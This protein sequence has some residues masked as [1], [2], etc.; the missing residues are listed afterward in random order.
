MTCIARVHAHRGNALRVTG[1]F[2]QA[3][4]ALA[5][6]LKT[7][8]EDGNGD[9]LVEAEMLS[10]LASL[11]TDQ[12]KAVEA[13]G[14]IDMAAGI[15]ERIG[16]AAQIARL[17]VK[18]SVVVYGTGEFERAL[19][20]GMEA[21]HAIDREADPKLYL[22]AEHNCTIFLYER[23]RYREAWDRLEAHAALYD[24]FP[25]AWTQLRRRKLQGNILRGLGRR[26]EA[27]E[28]LIAARLGFVAEGLGFYAA[29]A[30]LDLAYLY[31]EERRT[32]EVKRLAE[33]MVP[34]FMAQD[35]HREAAASAPPVP[36]SSATGNRHCGDA[37]GTHRLHGAG[38]DRAPTEAVVMSTRGRSGRGRR[39]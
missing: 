39:P 16:E 31:V 22:S 7:F 27:E 34:I 20:I 5:F 11:K 18:K 38:Q 26:R 23:T 4:E 2:K 35:I 33:E 13:E 28:A 9:P 36:R 8:D 12:G 19:S 37:Q 17:L 3:D 32:E 29:L 21:L 24:A 15:Y 14:Y 6:G 30:G 1:D 10:F 25:D